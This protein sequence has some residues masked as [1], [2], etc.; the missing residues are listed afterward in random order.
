MYS[1]GA[2]KAESILPGIWRGPGNRPSYWNGVGSGARAQTLIA[3]RPRTRSGVRR[4]LDLVH[5]ASEF[6]VE[7]GLTSTD[8]AAVTNRKREMV[9]AQ[10]AAHLEKYKATGADLVMGEAKFAGPKTL[11]VRLNDGGVRNVT[12]E[13][14]FLNLGTHASIPPTPGL[15]ECGPLTNIEAL[16]LDLLPEHLVVV[17]GGY[18][19]LEFAQAYRRFGSRVTILQRES[20]LLVK[21]DPD[22]SDEVQRILSAEGI[23]VVTSADI[24]SVEGRS[25][26]EVRLA[27]RTPE[28]ERRILASHVLVASGRTP[29]TAG[30]GLE[31]AGIELAEGGWIR[32][33]DRLETTAPGVWAIGECAGSPQFTHASLDDFRIIRD[34]LA[35]GS[36]STRGRLMPSCLFTDPQVAQVGLTETSAQRLGV[37]FQLAKVPMSSVLRTLTTG[38]TDG[39]MKAL[40]SPGDGQNSRLYDGW[41]RSRRSH[42]GGADGHAGRASIHRSARCHPG[43]PDDGRGT[44]CSVFIRLTRRVPGLAGPTAS[45]QPRRVPKSRRA[46]QPR[47]PA[48]GRRGSSGGCPRRDAGCRPASGPSCR[49]T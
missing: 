48:C 29:N 22:V 40:I 14:V 12:G 9:K 6:G 11:E 15:R 7:T 36:R 39:F 4:L 34:N 19:G 17:G 23:D 20:R 45:G 27:L 37:A 47:L 49:S 28:G 16:E 24:A 32:V 10:V 3:F 41:G 25:G 44:Q 30:I 31:T 21:Q 18:V 42:G 43:A 5:H 2:A 26:A 46:R 38:E 33:N 35:G 8:M 1:S 13:R